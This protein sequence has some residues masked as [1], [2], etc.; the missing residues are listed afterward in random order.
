M[1]L[2]VQIP[3]VSDPP[4]MISLPFLTDSPFVTFLAHLM[5]GVIVFLRNCTVHIRRR[6]TFLA[7]IVNFPEYS[8]EK[9]HMC[10]C[11]C[12]PKAT[13]RYMSL[14]WQVWQVEMNILRVV[15]WGQIFQLDQEFP[16]RQRQVDEWELVKAATQVSK[17][18]TNRSEIEENLMAIKEHFH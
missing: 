16:S 5:K 3:K 7:I 6:K 17:H 13:D 18:W 1:A 11:S 12:F 14:P 15:L 10:A 4:G 2:N 8:D 9:T